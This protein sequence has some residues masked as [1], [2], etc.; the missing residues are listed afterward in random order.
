METPVKEKEQFRN[1]EQ[2]EITAAA[3]CAPA[4]H[5]TMFSE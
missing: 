4:K 3:K 1:Y 2:G 5:S